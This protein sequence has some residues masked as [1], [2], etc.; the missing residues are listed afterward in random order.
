M[1]IAVWYNLPSG[2]GKRALYEHVQGLLK[3]GHSV[4]AWCPS[5]ADTHYLPLSEIICEHI[6][7]FHWNVDKL[8]TAQQKLKAGR[9]NVWKKCQLMEAHS[10]ECAQ[11]ILAGDFDVLLA[12]TCRLFAAPYIGRYLPN[13]PKVVYLQEPY[14]GIY[15]AA[16]NWLWQAIPAPHAASQLPHY[17]KHLF[18][19]WAVTSVLK[20]QA[21]EEQINARSYD[22]ILVNSLFSREATLRAYGIDSKVCYLG[23]NTARFRSIKVPRESFVMGIGTITPVKNIDLIIHALA[24]IPSTVRPTLVWVAN[25]FSERHLNELKALAQ[26][27]N[28][29][30]VAKINIDDD[31]LVTLLNQA[32]ALIYAPRL[33]P[34]GYPPLEAS[35]CETPV[36][37]VAEGGIRET[38]Q[39]NITGLLTT[40]SAVDLADSLQHVLTEPSYA[41]QLGEAGRKWTLETWS[42]EQASKRLEQC[43]Q[44]A[45]KQR[46]AAKAS[47]LV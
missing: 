46:S 6:K 9:W 12:C 15:E 36:I 27:S 35:A 13:M 5:I 44:D 34:F 24:E 47:Q 20:I 37:A 14:R 4:E 42:T 2:G 16:P 31:E 41:R 1:K 10:R 23:I 17:I 18:E 43:L 28:V 30:F 26:Q 11:E 22:A 40:H 25:G 33:E 45:I 29:N 32:Q 21:R 19:N 3:Q 39:H 7:P 8:A 38:V